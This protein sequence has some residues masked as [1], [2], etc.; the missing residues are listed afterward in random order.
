[1]SQEPFCSFCGKDKDDGR[2]LIAGGASQPS[3]D[4][5]LPPVF[6]C[7]RCVGLCAEILAS[8]IP[9]QKPKT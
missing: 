4:R 9:D 7:D 2:R 1:V 3:M 5:A 6:I 8:E